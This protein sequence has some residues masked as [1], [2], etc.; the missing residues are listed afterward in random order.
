MVEKVDKATLA[1]KKDIVFTESLYFNSDSSRV[2]SIT[3]KK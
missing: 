1:I 3:E 2:K